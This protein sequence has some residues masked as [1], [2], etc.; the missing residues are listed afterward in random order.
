VGAFQAGHPL[1]REE[2]VVIAH[3]VLFR[4]PTD[5]AEP[6]R[7]ALLDA[8]RAAFTG[9]AE[10]RRVRIGKRLLI[11]RGYETQMAEHYEYSAIIEF[12]SEADLRAYLNHPT[13]ADLGQRFF[14]S[15]EAALVYD[16]VIVEPDRVTDLLD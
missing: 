14:Q 4:P 9:I 1:A 13:H 6:D 12:D 8:M 7:Q 2:E 11:G 3:I 15:A 10:I 16:F 5:L